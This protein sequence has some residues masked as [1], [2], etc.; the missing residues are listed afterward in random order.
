MADNVNITAGAGTVVATDEVSIN[1]T[2]VQAQRMKLILG[3]DGTYTA[4]L[5]GRD[6]GSGDGA[7]YV[8]PRRKGIQIQVTPV[9]SNGVA[10]TSG[11][12]FGPITQLASVARVAGTPVRLKKIN[13]ASKVTT[14]LSLDFI[15]FDR[16]VTTAA[17]NAAYTISDSDAAFA[18]AAVNMP[19]SSWIASALNT[20]GTYLPASNDI[21]MTPNAS[22]IYVQMVTR[23]AVTLGSTSDIV[24]TFWFEQD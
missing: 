17:D 14:A 24:A 8:D 19:T 12:C 9:V 4:D 7:L 22:D 13:I 23:T 20:N 10:Y 16:A 2:T 5:A 11:D 18:Q 1:A 21:P 3:K 6:V 15:F